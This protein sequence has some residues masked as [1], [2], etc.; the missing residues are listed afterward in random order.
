MNSNQSGGLRIQFTLNQYGEFLVSRK[1]F[2]SNNSI[3]P[4]L[5]RKIRFRHTLDAR[6]RIV[7]TPVDFSHRS[8]T[9][10]SIDWL[11]CSE[12]LC[13]RQAS[14]FDRAGTASALRGGR[15]RRRRLL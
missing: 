1:T 14:S 11:K 3:W 2:E 10:L 13:E 9:Q 7:S 5:G 4:E 12:R 8:K 6:A 15:P